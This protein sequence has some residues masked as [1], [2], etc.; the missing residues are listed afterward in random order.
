MAEVTEPSIAELADCVAAIEAL[1]DSDL[2]ILKSYA[3]FMAF[4]A[5]GV[6]RYADADD[7]LHESI[8]RT[9]DGRR[10]WKPQEIDFKTH[11]K[12]CIRSITDEYAQKALRDLPE[13]QPPPVHQSSEEHHLRSKLLLET[14]TRLQGDTIAS[15]VFDHLLE[16]HSPA[17][18][19]QMLGINVNVYNA[20]RK[21]ISRC[22]QT[23]FSE[24]KWL[25]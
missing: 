9:L 23:A 10:K 22:M 18:V 24:W 11:I 13:A 5:K 7:L 15:A 2:R 3:R 4:R 21:R 14:R 1:S 8:A 12:G 25:L 20:A 19:R 6:L 17:D 16:G